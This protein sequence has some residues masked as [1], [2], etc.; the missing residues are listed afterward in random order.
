MVC[1]FDSSVG[2]DLQAAQHFQGYAYRRT[3]SH[4]TFP[5]SG[6]TPGVGKQIDAMGGVDQLYAVAEI[7]RYRVYPDLDCC[8]SV[9]YMP[10]L[11]LE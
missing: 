2:T 8:R 1:T 11:P 4:L 3:P 9:I 10:S 7:V 5:A 6:V